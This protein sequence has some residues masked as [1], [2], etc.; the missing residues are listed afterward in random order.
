MAL[1]RAA[2]H[3]DGWLGLVYTAEQLR[4]V[5]QRLNDYRA[6]AG[7]AEEPFDIL[8]ALAE[9][10]TPDLVSEL[11]E[12]GVTGLIGTPWVMAKRDTSSLAAKV[13]YIKRFEE[14]VI[15]PTE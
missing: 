11:E 1:K 8:L 15:R 6:E 14:H 9:R 13:E 2:R 10:T 12:L 5:I 3:G 7:R 4:P